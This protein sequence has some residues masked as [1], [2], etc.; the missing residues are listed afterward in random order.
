MAATFS[1]IGLPSFVTIAMQRVVSPTATIPNGHTSDVPMNSKIPKSPTRD[2]SN[3]S[4]TRAALVEAAYANATNVNAPKTNESTVN[5][6]KNTMF[7]KH[8]VQVRVDRTQ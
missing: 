2:Y 8:S 5:N 1:P 3:R 7:G 6:I 4:S